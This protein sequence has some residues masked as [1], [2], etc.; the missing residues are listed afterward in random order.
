MQELFWT[1]DRV[2]NR[3]LGLIQDDGDG[4]KFRLILVNGLTAAEGGLY[5]Y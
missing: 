5:F 2:T 3:D 1:S 4:G